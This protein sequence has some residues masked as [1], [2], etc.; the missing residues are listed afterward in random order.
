MV[1][2][3][4]GRGGALERHLDTAEARVEDD[5]ALRA[6]IERLQLKRRSVETDERNVLD[7][8]PL[9][10]AE[11]AGRII[12]GVSRGG[13]CGHDYRGGQNEDENESP[14]RDAH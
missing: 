11:R 5:G 1:E 12:F 8:G 4:I 2:R 7:C 10:S 3:A 9:L 13:A 14:H 6:S